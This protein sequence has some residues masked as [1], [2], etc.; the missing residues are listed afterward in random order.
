MPFTL[1]KQNG[2]KNW[3]ILYYLQS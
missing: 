2:N 1:A 3:H